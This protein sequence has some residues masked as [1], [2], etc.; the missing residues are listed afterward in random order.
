V[1]PSNMFNHRDLSRRKI[2]I[3]E[4]PFLHFCPSQP[5]FIDFEYME[6]EFE[7][8]R[9]KEVVGVESEF[10]DAF[11][12]EAFARREVGWTCWEQ[13]KREKGVSGYA[14]DVSEIFRE[15]CGNWLNFLGN[16]FVFEYKGDE[17]GWW[18]WWELVV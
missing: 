17:I 11:L 9:P 3:T 13:R 2:L 10:I 5:K 12:H 18:N 6:E 1:H 14:A 15:S 4:L 16:L 7:F 8:F